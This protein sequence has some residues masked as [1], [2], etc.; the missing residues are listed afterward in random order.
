M[1]RFS[2]SRLQNAQKREYPWVTD[3]TC[4]VFDA[5]VYIICLGA[6]FHDIGKTKIPHSVLNKSSKLRKDEWE[7]IKKHPKVGVNLISQ[8]DWAHHLEPMILLHHERLDGKG[9]YS[10]PSEKIPL[11][12][13]MVCVADAFDAMKSNRPYH[14][15][16]NVKAC[17]A[18]MERCSGTQFDPELLRL[19][20][21]IIGD[22]YLD[23]V[24]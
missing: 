24:K 17:W 13:R 10:V 18:E 9:Y 16:K 14:R 5:H 19:F 12:A 8:Y 15:K 1:V 2:T 23:K 3:T 21:S 6:L 20:R 4:S 22:I 7:L 11:S